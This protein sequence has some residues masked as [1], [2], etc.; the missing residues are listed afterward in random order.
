MIKITKV[1]SFENFM[2]LE[3]IWND[4]LYR[5]YAEPTFLRFEWISNWWKSF[6]KDKELLVLLAEEDEKIIGIAPLMIVSV[7]KFGVTIKKV[8][9]IGMPLSDYSDFII[10][11]RKKE[12]ITKFYDYLHENKNLWGFIKLNRILESSPTLDLMNKIPKKR[13]LF[14]R[15]L[16]DIAPCLNLEDEDYIKKRIKSKKRRKRIRRIKN[17]GN[18]FFSMLS[19]GKEKFSFLIEKF[20]EMHKEKWNKTK[21]PSMF[22]DKEYENFFMNVFT[23]LVDK[24]FADIFYFKI[25]DE[26]V[27]S[28][29]LFLDDKK[30]LTYNSSYNIKYSKFSP[31]ITT[32]LM[33]IDYCLSRDFDE[34]NFLRGNEKYKLELSNNSKK[35]F[36]L[37]IHK[38]IILYA[39]D[40]ALSILEKKIKENDKLYSFFI[41]YEKKIKDFLIIDS[42][43]LR[44]LCCHIF[45]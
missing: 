12:V 30:V 3:G 37:G 40:S 39:L 32:T 15:F 22:N 38:N 11:D 20:F 1:D 31:G 6:G 25:N 16:S 28:E 19:E 45:L 9:F 8:E 4:I 36:N 21:T 18:A 43:I 14:N 10:I 42:Y 44:F 13:L 35:I 34:V 17:E 33:M 29:I 2:E 26:I 5:S 7:K 24:G 27:S 23:S 41:K